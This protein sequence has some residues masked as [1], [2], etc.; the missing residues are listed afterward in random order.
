VDHKINQELVKVKGDLV[1][2]YLAALT[3]CPFSGHS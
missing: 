3:R 1:A 2:F